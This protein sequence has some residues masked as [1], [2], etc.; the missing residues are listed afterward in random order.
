MAAAGQ[1]LVKPVQPTSLAG[2]SV[3]EYPATDTLVLFFVV[4]LDLGRNVESVLSILSTFKMD[5][6]FIL[7]EF[8]DIERWNDS[9]AKA[10]ALFP[11][12]AGRLRTSPSNAGKKG[13][14]Y[15]QLTNS[16]IPVS[17]VDDYETT[18]FP[19]DSVGTSVKDAQPNAV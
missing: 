10:L 18:E 3:L 19:L 12:V 9:L 5:G 8:I 14:V 16:G 15:L 1:Y 4:S 17:V 6:L 7:P 2:R 11:P 13:G